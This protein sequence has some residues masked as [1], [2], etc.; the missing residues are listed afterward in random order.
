MNEKIESLYP[1]IAEKAV[2]LIPTKWSKLFLYS[3]ILPGVVTEV[4]Y[5]I[6]EDTG[7]AIQFGDI[8]KIYVIERS[9]FNRKSLGLTKLIRQMYKEFA[10]STPKVWTTMTFGLT[11]D[12]K[13]K[14]DYDYDK[15]EE[16]D[17]INRRQKW[18]MKYLDKATG[19]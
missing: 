16:T 3:E 12:G 13:F 9:E 11:S 7:K 10:N 19:G 5:F 8:P 2:E 18:E 1:Q 14:I 6:E 17:I 15:L 4:H